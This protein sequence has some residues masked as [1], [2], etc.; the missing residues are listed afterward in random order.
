MC[1]QPRCIAGLSIPL[2]VVL[3]TVNAKQARDPVATTDILDVLPADTSV[4]FTIRDLADFDGKLTALTDRMEMPISAYASLKTALQIVA[5]LE[6]HGS[7]AVALMPAPGDTMQPRPLAILLPTSDPKT[8]MTF[9][10]PQPLDDGYYRVTLRGREAYAGMKNGF[11]IFGPTL[12]T[13]Q[14]VVEAKSK[15]GAT[16][17][18]HQ[19]KR[20]AESDVAVWVKGP[21]SDAGFPC[22][23]YHSPFARGFCEALEA[24]VQW[25]N[26]LCSA[27]LD[28]S[29]LTLDL[30]IT[31]KKGAGIG[32]SVTSDKPPLGGTQNETLAMVM[33]LSNDPSGLRMKS[34]LAVLFHTL[35]AS[36]VLEPTKSDELRESYQQ[37]VGKV[38]SVHSSVALLPEGTG[39]SIGLTKI[40]SFR[41]DR[42]TFQN[43][44]ERIITCLRTG[45]FVDA[46]FNRLAERL[47][48]R[49]GAETLGGLAVDH[50]TL[51]LQGLS[52]L[53]PGSVEQLF[54]QQALIVR[55]GFADD[56]TL[57]TTLGGGPDHA[58]WRPGAV[59]A[60]AP[61]G[62]GP[63]R[64]AGSRQRHR[65]RPASS[66]TTL[67]RS[68]DGCRSTG[69]DPRTTSHRL[70]YAARPGRQ[71]RGCSTHHRYS[72]RN[73]QQ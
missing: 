38:S 66:Q 73:R 45:L 43:D 53:D 55:S 12:A 34:I 28:D 37:L 20:F 57:V 14:L 5:G 72:R 71:A 30:N 10:N 50:L 61:G 33:S 19:A 32:G 15:L 63:T 1:G 49:A 22:T 48:W 17:S 35:T 27:T 60:S 31:W 42:K 52:D 16:L 9:L 68:S 54:G 41:G 67:L 44:I 4:A 36:S 8:L 62:P 23:Q 47:E 56:Q 29:S 3:A 40:Q 64:L 69:S 46:R 18:P 59:S 6:D 39:G 26:L 2:L 11:A 24:Q 25:D 7:A 70:G 21:L 65:G 51:N 58:R 13:V